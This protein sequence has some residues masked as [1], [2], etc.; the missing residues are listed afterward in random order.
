M[1]VHSGGREA[2]THVRIC[3]RF[4]RC[5]FIECSLETGRT[6]QIRVHLAHLGYPL[7]GD[8]VY[9]GN[10]GEPCFDRQALHAWRLGLIHP[11]SGELM[12]WEL[13]LP[14]DFAQLLVALRELPRNES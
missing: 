8:V 6:H 4:V 7:V 1:A 3:E 2:R 12:H 10:R 13:P 9:G 14:E 11:R 5:T